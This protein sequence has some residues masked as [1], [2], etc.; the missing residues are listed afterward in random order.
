MRF[1]RAWTST[2]GMGT[3]MPKRYTTTPR[4]KVMRKRR[5]SSRTGFAERS[6][7][8]GPDAIVAA[9]VRSGRRLDDGSAGAFDRGADR[10]G[11]AQRHGHLA[12]DLDVGAAHQLDQRA[13]LD[14]AVLDQL[15]SGELV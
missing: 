8:P 6:P 15:L 14:D 3:R 9:M 10:L 2:P 11:H 1:S 4:R 12:I 5:I 7:P 13:R